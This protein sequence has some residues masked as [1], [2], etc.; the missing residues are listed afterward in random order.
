MKLIYIHQ[1]FRFPSQSGGTRSFDLATSFV[2]KGFEVDVIT[3]TNET[4][5]K[6]R[7]RWV[8]IESDGLKVHMMY[9]PFD[10]RL[11]YLKRVITFMK[12]IWFTS[13]KVLSL[14]CDLVLASST[15]LTI[16]IPA[17]IKKWVNNT[18]YI[19][20]VRDVWPEAVIAIG[21]VK[22]RLLQKILYYLEYRIYKNASAI[23][24]L[25]TDMK[26]SIITRYPNFCSKPIEVIENISEINRFQNGFNKAEF[27]LRRKIGFK[28]RFSILY[29]GTFGRV[30]GVEYAMNLAEKLF[31][32]DPSIIFILVGEGAEKKVIMKQAEK[33][34]ILNKT[35]F[36]LDSVSKQE[37]PQLYFECS[38]G[39]SFVVNIKELWS[40]S[41]NKFF[42]TLA[43][44]RPILINH[45]GWQKTVI[46][47]ENIGFVL[48]P[49]INEISSRKF[50][51]YTQN[52]QL[53]NI[54]QENALYIATEKYSLEVAV[55][56][57]IKIMKIILQ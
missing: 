55:S 1:Y 32:I 14:K 36:F 2:K 19:F 39:S 38:I 4:K 51:D 53:Q 9:L 31:L 33:K 50:A 11:S 45:H 54:Q 6:N 34:E 35:V 13:F 27:M 16:G 22:N 56:K 46:E 7:K 52:I 43:A 8:Q 28:P 41:A 44:G 40:N 29:A 21:A 15:P 57:Y 30:N 17:L 12:F 48:P 20:E 5:Y 10:N 47:E 25:S 24:P 3:S 18:P 23:I 49:H 26:D 42:D 37:L